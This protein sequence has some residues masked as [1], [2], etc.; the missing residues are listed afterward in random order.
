MP[1]RSLVVFAAGGTGG[2][3]FPA[4]AV[5]DAIGRLRNDIDVVFYCTSRPIDA[6]I[7]D[8]A[9]FSRVA[10]PVEPL[11]RRPWHAFRFISAWI[12]SHRLCRAHWNAQQP[13]LV[14]GTG[15]FGSLPPARVAH[16]RGIPLA[17]LNP[18]VIP[19]K[20]NRYLGRWADVAFVQWE[21]TTRHFRRAGRVC[22]SGCPVRSAFTE[23]DRVEAAS[24]FGLDPQ[25]RTLL[26]TGA[27]QGARTVNE[28]IM[29]LLQ[30]GRSWDGWQALHLTGD[31]DEGRVCDAY[32]SSGVP[33]K[34]LAFCDRMHDAVRAAD[35]VLSRA[36]ASTLAELTAVGRP[37]VLLPYPFHRDQHQRAN[38]DE[39]ARCGAAHVI[40]DRV[41]PAANAAQLGPLLKGLM[42]QPERLEAMAAASRAMGRPDAA[43]E[44][45]R[46]LLRLANGVAGN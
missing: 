9:G 29:R 42:Q 46:E 15:G 37:A 31:Q 36:G 13:S 11:P 16:R 12:A 3:L 33:G 43:E 27:S 45:A 32:A 39:L 8:P 38:A 6:Q 4:M 24:G 19:G 1:D 40:E 23:G 10:Q 44:V 18:D 26:I 20:A 34:V 2:H 22:V 41:D 17:L 28:V 30:T 5:A 35:L 7:L 25:L 14:V 21:A